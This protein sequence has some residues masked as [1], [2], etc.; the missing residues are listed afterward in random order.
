M[1]AQNR[2]N[3]LGYYI[4][5]SSAYLTLPKKRLYKDEVPEPLKGYN[6]M[7]KHLYFIEYKR[8]MLKE[9]TSLIDRGTFK[10]KEHI[11]KKLI[12]LI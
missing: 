4:A 6:A 8:A 3:L 5:L 7:L 11:N 1:L 10:D 2:N 12:L 9:F